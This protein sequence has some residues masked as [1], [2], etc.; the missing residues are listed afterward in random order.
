MKFRFV[1]ICILTCIVCVSNAQK[2]GNGNF[3]VNSVLSSGQWFKIGII[4]QGVHCL[5]YADMVQLGVSEPFSSADFR[6]YGNGGA[7]L[8]ESNASFRYDDLMEN[9][10]MVY[11]G[12]DGYINAGDSILFYG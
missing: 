9:P 12:G 2:S 4:Q 7:M 8:P 1:L 3:A 10:V 11:D 6:L 5:T